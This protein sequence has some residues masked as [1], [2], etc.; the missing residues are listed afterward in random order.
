MTFANGL[1]H[2]TAQT[3]HV[4]NGKAGAAVTAGSLQT[5][6]SLADRLNGTILEDCS[7]Q[8]GMRDANGAEAELAN[9][10]SPISAPNLK[11]LFEEQH[12]SKL[13]VDYVRCVQQACCQASM[14]HGALYVASC[15]DLLRVRR[16][17]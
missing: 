16:A 10:G 9:G 2:S 11:L 14:S 12:R 13:T 4:A 17:C 1:A 8:T 3:S 6:E 7:P 5:A 15:M